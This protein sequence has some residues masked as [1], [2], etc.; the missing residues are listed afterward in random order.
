MAFKRKPK[1]KKPKKTSKK[2]RDSEWDHDGGVTYEEGQQEDPKEFRRFHTQEKDER[3][4]RGRLKVEDRKRKQQFAS[5]MSKKVKFSDIWKKDA[6]GQK[7]GIAEEV[8]LKPVHPSS[9]ANPL[10]VLDRLQ[11]FL[12]ESLSH[13][14]KES[15]AITARVS[16]NQKNQPKKNFDQENEEDDESEGDENDDDEMDEDEDEIEEDNVVFDNKYSLSFQEKPTSHE[17]DLEDFEVNEDGEAPQKSKNHEDI[18]DDEDEFDLKASKGKPHPL[19]N[20]FNSWYFQSKILSDL[21][22]T[23]EIQKLSTRSKIHCVEQINIPNSHDESYHWQ[24][25]KSSLYQSK[26][27]SLPDFPPFQASQFENIQKIPGIYKLWKHSSH[28]LP[29]NPF[30]KAIFPKLL[31]YSDM[32]IE[33]RNH[34]NDTIVLEPLLI[35]GLSHVIKSR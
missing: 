24:E 6:E 13:K 23:V 15:S 16:N 12:R 29:L 17:T 2:G 26:N 20:P 28:P 35:H 3:M 31:T 30:A 33:G 18:S 10:P 14:N 9:N 34:W 1:A 19:E 7:E 21:E 27:K 8:D 11:F 25:S 4:R 32:F 5:K 22:K